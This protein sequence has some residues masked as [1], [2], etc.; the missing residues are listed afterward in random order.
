MAIPNIL[1]DL[2]HFS[3]KRIKLFCSSFYISG[4]SCHP[5]YHGYVKSP[6][7]GDVFS[8]GLRAHDPFSGFMLTQ[9][10]FQANLISADRLGEGALNT[11]RSQ[12]ASRLN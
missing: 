2:L 3:P 11:N 12:Y 10:L 4:N 5:G 8:D 1:Y 6:Y 9:R 7:G